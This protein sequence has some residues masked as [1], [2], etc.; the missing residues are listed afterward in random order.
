MIPSANCEPQP[1]SSPA[2]SSGVGLA[3]AR[4][5]HDHIPSAGNGQCIDVLCRRVKSTDANRAIHLA[6]RANRAHRPA[7]RDTCRSG[8]GVLRAGIGT[9][10]QIRRRE[11]GIP[12]KKSK[13]PK[14][15]SIKKLAEF[16]ETH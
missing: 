14:T 10:G 12:M 15:D 13:L 2:R 9:A 8:G 4:G 5:T 3:G 11:S 16:W 6:P 7:W 1:S